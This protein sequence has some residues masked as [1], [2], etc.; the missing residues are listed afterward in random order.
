MV[1]SS[2][3]L[4][5]RKDLAKLADI[6]QAIR[7]VSGDIQLLLVGAMA[8]DL[9]LSYTYGIQITRATEDIDVAI[10]FPHWDAFESLRRGLIGTGR[11]APVQRMPHR[12]RYESGMKL[13]L[14]P[15]GEIEDADRTIAWPPD[16]TS[17]MDVLGFKEAARRAVDVALIGDI[18]LSAAALPMLMVLKLLAWKQRRLSQPGKDAADIWLLLRH[19]LQAGNGDRLYDEFPHLLALEHFDVNEAGAWMLGHDA[20]ELL[21]GGEDTY[22]LDEVL[23]ISSAEAD[24]DG[25]LTLVRDIRNEPAQTTLDL[26]SAFDAALKGDVTRG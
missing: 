12:L 10:A 13:D 22:A 21:S 3:D 14:I 17:V 8:R 26:L 4:S 20:R 18:H 1:A 5:E 11:F 9:L 19:Y 23:K 15:F 24:P 2:I 25:A 6:I 7:D 16:Q